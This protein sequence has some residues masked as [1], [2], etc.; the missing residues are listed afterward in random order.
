[1]NHYA[2]IDEVK[3]SEEYRF[4]RKLGFSEEQSV[5]W[6]AMRFSS[7]GGGFSHVVKGWEKRDRGEKRSF[8]QFFCDEA[9]KTPEPAKDEDTG[10]IFFTAGMNMPEF[11]SRPSPRPS[12][13]PP[14]SETV[15]MPGDGAGPRR[16]Q[17]IHPQPLFS[18]IKIQGKTAG[19]L[20]SFVSAKEPV[21][22]G[23]FHVDEEDIRT[24]S[25][26]VIE[27][28]GER[29]TVVSPTATFR[30][31]YNTA[32][33]GICLSNI[34]NGSS[35]RDSMV[36][37]EELLNYLD[38]DLQKPE[39]AKF[40]LTAELKR[41]GNGDAYLFLG[42]KG[43]EVEKKALNICFILDVSGSMSSRDEQMKA[44][45][46][47]VLSKMGDGDVFSLVT[48]STEDR[49][50]LNGI[51]MGKDGVIDDM[52]FTLMAHVFIGGYTHGSAGLNKAY[53]IVA[54]HKVKDGVNRVIILT[55]GDLNFGISDK[56]GLKGLIEKRK[57][58][59]AYF[60]AIGTGIYNLKDDKLE[61]LA[62]NG[63]GNYF[64]VNSQEDVERS[65]VDDNR[66]MSLVYPIAKNVKAQMEFNPAKVS[67]WQLIGYENR[68]LNHEDFRN[69]AVI[70]E[71]FGSGSY[72]VALFKIRENKEGS[73][74]SGLKYQAVQ[75][76]ESSELGTLTLRYEDVDDSA[77]KE[78]AFPVE[79]EINA[80]RNIEKAILCSELAE[81]MRDAKYVDEATK[82]A[83][84]D[85][86]RR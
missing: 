54:R 74:K 16:A 66:F 23:M 43:K 19:I 20:P 8:P 21:V 32:A 39:D 75:A 72:F 47:T 42:V 10:K 27:E 68:M 78:I 26:E 86:C 59:G 77:V 15:M 85:L 38:Y 29:E 76:V 70:A 82:D 50:V 17:A 58:E 84:T 53:D 49:V 71:P 55:D 81:K 48:Y 56:D 12:M 67:H 31:T 40:A 1:M 22:M 62:K 37:T 45:I 11:L 24:D 51:R 73:V 83:F 60:S 7:P 6:A 80:T 5:V 9:F 63:N 33:A 35:L 2:N 36:R 79:T 14:S 52:L 25:Y 64:V 13:T 34:R 4:Y 65:L 28:K 57:K 18:N 30:P 3:R 44:S 61:A 69:D 46:A 41:E